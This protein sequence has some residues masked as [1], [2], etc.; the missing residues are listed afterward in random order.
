ME[1]KIER[2]PLGEGLSWVQSVVDRKTTMPI[3]SNVLLEAKGSSLNLTATDL[4]VGISGVV[5]ADVK[6]PGSV[7]VPARGL[8]EVVKNLPNQMVTLKTKENNWI[9][10]TCAKSRFKLVGLDAKEFP[11][12]PKKEEGVEF[13]LDGKILL[14]MIQKVDFAISTD[15]TR[16]NLNGILVEAGEENGKNSFKMVATDGHRLSI[17]HRDL[18]KKLPL[19]RAVLFP[20]KGVSELK[21]FLE[22]EEGEVQIWVG[23]KHA[24]IDFKEK[25]LLLRLIDGQFPPYAHVVPTKNKR[26]LSATKESLVQALR[27]VAVVTTDRSRGVK[28]SI[29]PGNLEIS[30]NNPDLGEAKE[31]LTAQYKGATFSIGFNAAYFLEALHV[32]EDEQVVLQLGDEVSPCLLQSETDRGFTHVIMPM[33][34]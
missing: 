25:R 21:R 34:I 12:L 9:E 4:E 17:S 10:V 27:R 31:E 7:T 23:K 13:Q 32:L 16:Y 30:A 18:K 29:S 26:V 3:L 11:Q 19:S 6:E 33:R 15:E 5:A 20:R 1:I 24:M 28:F 2:T 22:G 14:E 8:Y